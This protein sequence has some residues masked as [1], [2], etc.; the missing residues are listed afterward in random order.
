MA[1]V[2]LL[3]FIAVLGCFALGLGLGAV[4]TW[5][6]MRGRTQPESALSDRFAALAADALRKNNES[7]LSL[8]ESRLKQSEITATATFD[9]KTTAIDE[10]LKPVKETLGKMDS[11]LQALEVARHG[12]YK[13]L[14]KAVDL[15]NEGQR[16]LRTE[17]NQ[18]FQ[19]LH[20]PTSRGQWG[21]FQ[22]RRILEMTGMTEHTKDFSAQHHIAAEDG[23]LRPDYVV[24]LPGHRCVVIDS[25]VPLSA[26][27]ESTQASDKESKKTALGRHA[28]QVREHIRALSSKA[29]WNHVD[30]SADFVVLFVPG[31]HFLSAA[32]EC[33]PDLFEFGT[34]HN[35]LLATP[36]TLVALL[37]TVALSWQQ[38]NLRENAEKIG[39]LGGELYNAL[40]VMTGHITKMGSKL[41]E[42]LDSYNGFIGSLE[43]NVLS[44]ARRLRDFGA[45]KE[46]RAL[47]EAIEPIDKAP[48]FL[49]PLDDT[50]KDAES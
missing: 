44:K 38:E 15:S 5:F 4:G 24:W 30:G 21:E 43:R 36:V 3:S 26:Y 41:S 13:E 34:S 23:S 37:R 14:L 7:F 12:A 50:Q 22:I 10:M 11:Q 20:A 29:Y 35:V 18:L 28:K 47:P 17:T 49:Q 9:K 48:R 1:V 25:K 19:A 31:D 42:S 39:A 6:L 32:L 40:A 8:A 27:Q 2:D 16:A 46:G 33:E 45:H